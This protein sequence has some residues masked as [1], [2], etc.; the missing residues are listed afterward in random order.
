MKINA[1]YSLIIA[2]STILIVSACQEK[3]ARWQFKETI[4]LGEIQ[5]IGF[6]K[7]ND[8]FWISDAGNNRLIKWDKQGN[9]VK[10]HTGF[11]RPMHL[12]YHNEILYI[13]EYLSDT[14]K[15]LKNGKTNF[16][17][18]QKTPDAPATIDVQNNL[19]AIADFYNHR[20]IL[21]Q[22]KKTT[23]IGKKGHNDGE[24]NYPTD[25]KIFDSLLYVADAYN[26]RV[27]V[28]NLNGEYVKMIGWNDTIKVASG[29]DVSRKYIAVA[30]QENNRALIYNHQGKLLQILRQNID[31]PT[32]VLLHKKELYVINF[33]GSSICFYS[34]E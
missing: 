29:L 26:N 18:L 15:T 21:Q 28:F 1:H 7:V 33:Q 6:V 5:P 16:L 19:I 14:I 27:Q 8:Y 22:G 11:Q 20:I 31:Y 4:D 9:I 17:P 10:K 25:V 23:T 13:P 30:D 34:E 24:L 12:A 3:K 2:L 32:D